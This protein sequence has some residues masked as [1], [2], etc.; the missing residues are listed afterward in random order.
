MDIPFHGIGKCSSYKMKCKI[1][2]SWQHRK[3]L[4]IG[5]CYG[6]H[7]CKDKLGC[8]ERWRELKEQKEE[9]LE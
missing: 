4:K 3:D 2:K 5:G 7:I 8:R 6:G 9:E 1:C